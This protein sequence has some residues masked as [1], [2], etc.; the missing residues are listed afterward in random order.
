[1]LSKWKRW[2]S[3]KRPQFEWN[4][5]LLWTWFRKA[6]FDAF[7]RVIVFDDIDGHGDIHGVEQRLLLMSH[8]SSNWISSSGVGPPPTAWAEIKS[9]MH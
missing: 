7:K 9:E 6:T 3:V 5:S 8:W 2:I 1:M 4:Y